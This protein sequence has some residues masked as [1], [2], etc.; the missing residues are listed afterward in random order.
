MRT[1]EA[2]RF[3]AAPPSVV[4]R[5]LTPEAV[6]E[7]EG[8]FDVQEVAEGDADAEGDG[9]TLVRAARAGLSMVFAFEDREDGL[10]YEQL[11]GPLETLTTTIDYRPENEGTR[12]T[13]E[14]TLEAGIGP[15]ER[16]AGWKRRG[17]LKRAL[18]NLD[19]QC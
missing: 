5:V 2:S 7:A 8:S 6:I 3:V 18:R 4:A 12:L 10:R 15:M 14:S 17:E 11:D 19:K 13:A 9:E 16:L 1:V